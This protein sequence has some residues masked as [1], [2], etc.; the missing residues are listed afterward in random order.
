MH[1]YYDN[2]F[3]FILGL[4]SYINREI[5]HIIYLGEAYNVKLNTM[6]W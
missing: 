3:H 1:Y 5:V 2:N 4:Y 6:G